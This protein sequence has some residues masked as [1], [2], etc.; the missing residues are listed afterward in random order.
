MAIRPTSTKLCMAI[1]YGGST[2]KLYTL[3]LNNAYKKKV[4]STF[5][6]LTIF[7]I[8]IDGATLFSCVGAFLSGSRSIAFAAK[9][10]R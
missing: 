7:V 3:L 5:G 1:R 6:K 8:S 4:F 10:Q 2:V 9:D